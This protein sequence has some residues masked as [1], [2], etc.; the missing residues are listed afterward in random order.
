MPHLTVQ[1]VE[2]KT[3]AQKQELAQELVKTAQSILGI[4]EEAFSVGIREYTWDQWKE[5]VYPNDIMGNKDSL[6]KQ[7]GYEV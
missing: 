7:P 6:Y 4:G 1:L 3:E 5:T 2:G